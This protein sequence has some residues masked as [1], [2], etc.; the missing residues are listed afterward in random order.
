MAPPVQHQSPALHRDKTVHGPGIWRRIESGW[1]RECAATESGVSYNQNVR[2]GHTELTVELPFTTNLSTAELIQRVRNAWLL[3]HSTRPEIAIQIS[4]GTELPQRL[5]F[6]PLWTPAEAAA[7]LKETFHVVSDADARDV[8]RMTYSRR[9]PTKGKRN[10]LYLVTAGAASAEDPERHCLV[11]NFSHVLADV[12]SVVQFFNHFF[13]TVT[14]VAGDRDLDVRELDYSRLETRLP[15]TPMTPYE[16]RYQPI[17]EQREQAID[18]ALAQAE[19]YTAKMPQSIA[20]YPEPDTAA[21]PHGTHCIRLRYTQSESEALLAALA[22]QKV[23]ITFAAAA[24]T[25]LS[26]KQTYGRG[27]ETGALLGM[28]RNARRWV[29]TEGRHRVPNA[30]DV[31]FLW[32]PFKPEWFVPGTSTQEIVFL[33]AREIRTQLGP[34]LISPHYIS[35]LSFTADRFI[36]NLAAE[37][38]PIP[39]PQAPGFSPQGALPLQR[40]FASSRVSIRTHDFVH[41]GRQI[42]L[43]A[44]V[45]MFSLWGR[46][47]LSMGFDSKYYDPARMEAFME[48]VKANLGSLQTV[49]KPSKLVAQARL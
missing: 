32:I 21:R 48:R 26:I 40:D 16:E 18:G 45:G 28:T 29:D 6:E 7:W 19:L 30:A 46:V 22:E 25:V 23:S 33:L 12:Y 34:H 39:S 3:C 43:S 36:A 37:G 44:W 38:E 31:V 5:V 20:M 47:T 4:T 15:L 11:W 2:D 10:M 41:T 49:S 24:A 14:E 8:A 27:H 13:R 1:T 35:T 42:N 9:L 17:S